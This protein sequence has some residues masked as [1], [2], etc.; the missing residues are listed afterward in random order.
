MS[1]KLKLG[2]LYG[3]ISSEREVSINTGKQII[4]A[5]NK[6]KYDVEGILL[7]NKEDVFKCKGFDFIF[8]ALHGEFGEDGQV[9]SILD[10][11]GIRYNGSDFLTSSLCMNK[12]LVK[13]VLSDYDIPMAKGIIVD[14]DYD[15]LNIDLNFPVIIKPNI[16]GSSVGV[17]ICKTKDKLFENVKESFLYDD[18]LLIEEFIGGQEI[19]CGILNGESLPILK[20]VPRN[21]DFFNYKSKYDNTTIEEPIDLPV[22]L[23]NKIKEISKKCHSVLNC[24][25]YSRV[26]FILRDGIPYFLEINTLPGMTEGSLFPKIAR[27]IGLDFKSLLDNIIENSNNKYI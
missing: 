2:V 20:I 4:Y 24:R 16:G 17:V 3:G 13:K 7:N 8:I 11:M 15:L 27:L 23:D 18:H 14:R 22:E 10:A 1:K 5:L 9:Q 12:Y 21:N 6:E 19:T 25:V 26:D